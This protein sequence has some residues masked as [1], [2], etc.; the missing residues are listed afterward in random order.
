MEG[1]DFTCAV[2]SANVHLVPST[3]HNCRDSS[4]TFILG[5]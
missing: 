3:Y 5:P 4:P 1:C 2:L